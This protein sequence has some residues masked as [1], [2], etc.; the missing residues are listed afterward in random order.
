[1][2][3]LLTI[4]LPLKQPSVEKSYCRRILCSLS[5]TICDYKHYI[6]DMMGIPVD[7]LGRMVNVSYDCGSSPPPKSNVARVSRG[8]KAT[9]TASKFG[10]D[11]G[12]LERHPSDHI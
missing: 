11:L 5:D 7:E 4:Q 9:I 1:M 2:N 8:D 6:Q 10:K 12:K 3:G